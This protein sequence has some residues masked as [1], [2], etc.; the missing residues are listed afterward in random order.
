[1]FT[2]VSPAGLIVARN[3]ALIWGFKDIPFGHQVTHVN[4]HASANKAVAVYVYSIQTGAYSALAG[5]STGLSNSNIALTTP[6]PYAVDKCILVSWAPGNT[7]DKLF[8][9]TLT[10]ALI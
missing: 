9:A 10:L 3:T 2:I 8:G 5:T 7:T 4:V 1:M 6:I